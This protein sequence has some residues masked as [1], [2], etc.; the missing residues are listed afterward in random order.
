MKKTFEEKRRFVFELLNKKDKS[1]LASLC[2]IF[3]T[4]KDIE[5][6]YKDKEI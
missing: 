1:S 6:I 5:H 2:L 3:M 4:K